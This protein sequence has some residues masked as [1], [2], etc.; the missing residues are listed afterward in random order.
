MFTGNYL[1]TMFKQGLLEGVH[2]FTAHTFKLALFTD[3]ATLTAD[4]AAYST[5]DE[6]AGTGYTA[7]GLA[8]TALTPMRSGTT[9]FVTFADAVW[10]AASLTARGGRVYNSSVV[11]NPAVA[12]LDFG[13]N[14][15]T[16]NTAFT[17]HFPSATATTAVIRIV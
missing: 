6:V 8:L 2:D 16:N 1:V 11:G 9:A 10:P 12:V 15:I 13:S 17:V 7:G 5:G 14:K 3:E 4:T